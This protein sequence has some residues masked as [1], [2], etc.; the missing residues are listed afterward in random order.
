MDATARLVVARD[1]R[2]RTVP[3]HLRAEAPLLIRVTDEDRGAG[4]RVHLVGGAAGPL[5]G[6][7]LQLSVDVGDHADLTV[8]SVAASLA[9]P[10]RSGA[11]GSTASVTA[12]VAA[13][14]AL[15]WWPEPIVSVVGSDHTQTTTVTV[16]AGSGDVRWVDEI[17][18]GRHDQRSGRLTVHQ[19]FVV[20][21]VPVLRHTMTIDPSTAGIGR[22]GRHR[23]VVTGVM[24]GGD[25]TLVDAA[26]M[27]TVGSGVRA[28]RYSIAPA[29]T[30]WIALA[31]DLDLAR[32]ALGELG[33]R[34]DRTAV[35][36]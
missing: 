32:A 23:V 34:R 2:G 12:T 33:L 4:L 1:A 7:R 26:S 28:A 24:V 18:L 14:G 8:R 21:G 27:S 11:A 29:C 25:A 17:V 31:D 22:I 10:G 36:V 20:A 35:A 13:D 6:D 19:R 15:D 5:A 16:A 30:A 9:Q 3:T